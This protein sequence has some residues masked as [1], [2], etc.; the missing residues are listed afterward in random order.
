MLYREVAQSILIFGLETWVIS[1]EMERKVKGDHT[2]F[3]I[4]IT[5]KQA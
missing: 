3:L 2:G 4:Q 1:A 5:G